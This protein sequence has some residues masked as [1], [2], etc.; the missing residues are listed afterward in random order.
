MFD[1]CNS[2]HCRRCNY[3]DP[4]ADT[5][6]IDVSLIEQQGAEKVV[7]G[8]IKENVVPFLR[9]TQAPRTFSFEEEEKSHRAVAEAAAI[10]EAVRREREDQLRRRSE[11]ERLRPDEGGAESPCCCDGPANCDVAAVQQEEVAEAAKMA[12]AF[13]TANGFRSVTS[14]RRRMLRASYPLHVAVKQNRADVVRLLLL[15]KADPTQRNSSGTSPWQLAQKL[16]KNGSHDEVLSQ[17]R[18]RSPH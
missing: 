15:A 9:L 12:G 5:V 4:A 1:S 16:C 3:V 18:G 7:N 2:G 17:L 6:T 13:L 8:F 14:R 11:E 10:V